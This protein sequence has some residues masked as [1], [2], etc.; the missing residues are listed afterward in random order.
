MN[1]DLKFLISI[2]ERFVDMMRLI[3]PSQLRMRRILYK[4]HRYAMTRQHLNRSLNSLG[5]K[6]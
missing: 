5:R 6:I 2:I 3:Y 1:F 4:L